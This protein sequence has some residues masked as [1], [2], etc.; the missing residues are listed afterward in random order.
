MQE[1]IIIPFFLT[2]LWIKMQRTYNR[3]IITEL[4]N[5]VDVTAF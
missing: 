1:K 5:E 4:S 3:K 2:P